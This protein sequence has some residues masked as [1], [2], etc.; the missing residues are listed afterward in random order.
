MKIFK[1]K[2]ILTTFGFLTITSAIISSCAIS[3]PDGQ[4]NHFTNPDDKIR[5]QQNKELLEKIK[6]R[7]DRGTGYEKSIYDEWL[8]YEKESDSKKKHDSYYPGPTWGDG[9]IGISIGS[10]EQSFIFNGEINPPLIYG[11]DLNS[12]PRND[13]KTVGY[14][15]DYDYIYSSTNSQGD[16]LAL[17]VHAITLEDAKY[18]KI[19]HNVE[20]EKNPDTLAEINDVLMYTFTPPKNT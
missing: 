12:I 5:Q 17:Y 11:E 4:K 2:R 18:V 15:F 1:I 9:V 16:I 8:N 6:F 10:I 13:F 19:G 14:W 20:I 3:E 7:Q